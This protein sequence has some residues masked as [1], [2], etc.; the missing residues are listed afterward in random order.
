VSAYGNDPRVVRANQYQYDVHADDKYLLSDDVG[1]WW[2][3]LA[4]GAQGDI[5]AF[6]SRGPFGTAD[7]AIRS[8]IEDPRSE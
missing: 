4:S 5:K 6:A 3:D 8:L 7:E 2:I 1:G